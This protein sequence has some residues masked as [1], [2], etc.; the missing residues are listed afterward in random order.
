MMQIGGKGYPFQHNGLTSLVLSLPGAVAG[1]S[2]SQTRAVCKEMR[3]RAEEWWG[4]GNF[5][6]ATS[7]IS[8]VFGFVCLPTAVIL[9]CFS[10]S[11]PLLKELLVGANTL[12]IQQMVEASFSSN[13]CKSF[14][15]RPVGIVYTGTGNGKYLQLQF[16]SYKEPACG[17][18]QRGPAP[19][20]MPSSCL[21]SPRAISLLP[22]TMAS[23]VPAAAFCLLS[24]EPGRQR[25]HAPHFQ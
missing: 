9:F 20:P 22:Y 6:I 14:S 15:L 2:V 24:P 5:S 12:M 7:V 17:F 13:Q 1:K 11:Y 19:S 21:C 3:E 25:Y 10:P 16:S 4:G 18:V 23:P 8:G